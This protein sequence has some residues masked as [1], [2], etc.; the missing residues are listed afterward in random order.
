MAKF[1]LPSDET[2]RRVNGIHLDTLFSM[3]PS[4]VIDPERSRRQKYWRAQTMGAVALNLVN[5]RL[6]INSG[7]LPVTHWSQ[8]YDWVKET[9]DMMTRF[10]SY[11]NNQFSER[12]QMELAEHAGLKLGPLNSLRLP[13]SI[14][15]LDEDKDIPL[16]PNG[17]PGH[18]LEGIVGIHQLDQHSIAAYEEIF[19]VPLGN[20]KK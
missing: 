11:S 20:P 7:G 17:F 18:R 12:D 1:E 2:I 3:D 15:G 19:K 16:A 4:K 8:D 10:G 14:V 5:G 9:A 13:I 6:V